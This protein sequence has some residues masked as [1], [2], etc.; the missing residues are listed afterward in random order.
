[1]VKVPLLLILSCLLC[2]CESHAFGF[3][4]HET[5]ISRTFNPLVAVWG[6]SI[7]V[8]V[9]FTNWES[10][11]LRAFYYV[12]QIPDELNVN[13]IS[14]K[15]N[16]TDVLGYTSESGSVG[17]VYA[18][19]VPH[20]W[21][22]E[23]PPD[24]DENNPIEANS[25]LE[26]VYSVGS[27]LFG[28]FNFDEFHW[29]GYYQDAAEGQMAAFGCSEDAEKQ[30]ITFVKPDNS[31]LIS[32]LGFHS[33]EGGWIES[34]SSD[35][36]HE[37]WIRIRWPDYN[38]ANG[39]TRIAIGDIDGDGKDEI[40]V[41]LGP[42]PGDPATPGGWFEVF[43][44][45][46][47]HLA[48]GRVRYAAYNSANGEIWPAC[49][50][51]DDDSRDEI[52]IGL[53]TY[54]SDGG[55][56]EI[57]D[58]ELGSINH[59]AWQRVR[60]S[61]YNVSNGETRPAC[62]DIDGDGKDE[63]V[64][65]LGPVPGDPATPGGWFEIFDDDL[66]HLDWGMVKFTGYN[67]VNGETWPACGDVDGDGADEIVVGLG[68]YPANGG[69]FEFFDYDSGS[70]SHKAWENTKWM[71][72]NLHNGETRPTCGD[73]D[74]DGRDEIIIGLGSGGDGYMKVLDDYDE[75]YALMA[76]PSITWADYCSANGETRPVIQAK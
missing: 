52:I 47:T 68:S 6:E 8:T 16:G 22:L 64:V 37:D 55:W 10:N 49:G 19:C 20:R 11:D 44:D 24:F 34:F 27:D 21:I 35:Y 13:R 66:S 57:F 67:N 54:P 31:S 18:G 60:W 51:V 70:L 58:Y 46:Y 40:V 5:T 25:I 14:V 7:T 53:G 45:D 63:I 73:I 36:S 65:G 43:D 50:D 26:I 9:T 23:V 71:D 69:W 28:V 38:T 75:A 59:Q 1:M 62:G 32:G 72:Y 30:A 42:V 2:L 15:I 48:W 76:W 61:T 39:E 3:S 33:T 74:E 41:G 17:D 12:D 56:F 4:T 29:V